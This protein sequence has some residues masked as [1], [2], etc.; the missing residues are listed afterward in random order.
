MWTQLNVKLDAIIRAPA[1][2][3]LVRSWERAMHR[4]HTGF[5]RTSTWGELSK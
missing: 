5:T 1:E 2:L 4:Q 3:A